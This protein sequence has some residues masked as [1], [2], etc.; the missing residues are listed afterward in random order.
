MEKLSQLLAKYFDL[1]QFNN[2]IIID[3]LGWSKASAVYKV[4][5][6]DKVVAKD[7]AVAKRLWDLSEK[8]TG[9]KWNL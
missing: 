3:S 9:V 2:Y 4:V 7:K 5:D 6:K 1:V 8:E